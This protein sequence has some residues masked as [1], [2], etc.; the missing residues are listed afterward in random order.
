MA[1]MATLIPAENDMATLVPVA[2]GARAIAQGSS[3]LDETLKAP[4]RVLG[5]IAE[6]AGRAGQYLSGDRVGTDLRRWG[7]GIEDRNA[8]TPEFQ[9]EHPVISTVGGV[10]EG[11]AKMAPYLAADTALAA[12]GVGAP[13]AAGLALPV[14]AGAAQGQTSYEKAIANGM[15][16]DEAIS[17]SRAPAVVTGAGMGAMGVL[18]HE[19]QGIGG[20]ARSI[21]GKFAKHAAADTAIMMGQGVAT[22]EAE[23]L[24]S[25]DPNAQPLD[26]LTN[27]KAWL[28]SALTGAL[29][30]GVGAGQ[31]IMAVRRLAGANT[32]ETY[33][34][35]TDALLHKIQNPDADLGSVIA[36][37][38]APEP[39][40]A[41]PGAAALLGNLGPAFN[42][43]GREAAMRDAI[44]NPA[45][46]GGIRDRALIDYPDQA[47]VGARSILEGMDDPY[48]RQQEAMA[49]APER[50]IPEMVAQVPGFNPEVPF[51][52]ERSQR[53]A[54][55][56]GVEADQRKAFDSANPEIPNAPE[57]LPTDADFLRSAARNVS[58]ITSE[59]HIIDGN[60]TERSW[61]LKS[62]LAP[63]LE[64]AG[65]KASAKDR[66]AGLTDRTLAAKI[67]E[68][69]ANG[70]M[71]AKN[72]KAQEPKVIKGDS[73]FDFGYND[74]NYTP[75]HDT[76]PY[77]HLSPEEKALADQNDQAVAEAKTALADP[78][79]AAELQGIA[80]GGE[81]VKAVRS[82]DFKEDG[83]Y[84]VTMKD[85]TTYG[86][87]RDPEGGG[88]YLE[89]PGHFTDAALAAWTKKDAITALERMHEGG[90][91]RTEVA[92][93]YGADGERL[94]G[95]ALQ[96]SKYSTEA[97]TPEPLTIERIQSAFPG[98]KV[99]KGVTPE[100]QEYHSVVTKS[101]AVFMV[102]QVDGEIRYNKGVV[103]AAYG[104]PLSAGETP[105]ASWTPLDTGSIDRGG[106]IKLT[107]AGVGEL[108]HEV[109]HAAV[110]LALTKGE[111]KAVLK[112]YGNEEAAARAY[113]D[114]RDAPAG[115]KPDTFFQKIKDFFA[116]IRELIAPTAQG[117]FEKIAS[118]EAWGNKIT[119]AQAADPKYSLKDQAQEKLDKVMEVAPVRKAAAT[120][121]AAAD[122]IDRAIMPAGR[123][124]NAGKAGE[125]L[126][127]ELGKMNREV[128]QF[129][130]DLDS[131]V[132]KTQVKGLAKLLDM[133][134]QSGR[135]LADSVFS[136]L[137]VQA[138]HD[139]MQW[140]DTGK[141]PA[142]LDV[143]PEL[144]SIGD[145]MNKEFGKL[146]GEVQELGTH[147]LG[148]IRENYFPH[149]YEQESVR[150]FN[151]ALTEALDQG[152]GG[153]NADLSSWSAA[154]K[155][156][157]RERAQ[158]LAAAGQGL[159]NE[160]YLHLAKRPVEGSRAFTKA[161]VFD[162]IQ[163]AQDFGLKL[164][165]D[166]PI[167]LAY[168]KINEMKKYIMTHTAIKEMAKEIP[169]SVQILPAG[170]QGPKGY[171]A[172]LGPY[173][174]V[175]QGEKAQ[176]PEAKAAYQ[177]SQQ[178]K[179]AVA[180]Q[181][182]ALAEAQAQFG[183]YSPEH[184]A[185]SDQLGK[186]QTLY[187]Q[188]VSD[189]NTMQAP[190]PHKYW[191]KDDVA[192]IY[193]NYL[194]QTLYNNKYVGPMYSTWMK[195]A[196]LLNQWQLGILSGF[197]GGFTS[198]ES[199]LS[200]GALGI[201]AI[202][203]GDFKEGVKFLGEAPMAWLRNPKFGDALL[204]VYRDPSTAGAFAAR[205]EKLGIT[206]K[207]ARGVVDMLELAG[208]KAGMGREFETNTT[209]KAL[210][211][212][213]D[214]KKVKAIARTPQALVEQAARPIMEWLV[215][216]QKFG[217]FGEMAMD[218]MRRNPDASHDETRK[219]AQQIWNRID[220]RLGQVA[221]D[222]L[223]IHNI[224]K[225]VA[226]A[227]IRAP[228]WTG[229]TVLEL[230]GG[231]K[232]IAGWAN[233][234]RK[235]EFAELSDRA[236][237]TI[238]L[239]TGMALA[240]GL[241]TALFTGDIPDQPEDLWAFRTG[242]LD[243]LGRP[244][245]YLLPTY[246]KDVHNWLSDPHKTAANKFHPLIGLASELNQNKDY[247]STE[248][249][250]PD[251]NWLQQAGQVLGYG[252]KAF[253]PFWMRGMGKEAER[254]AT[255]PVN[256]VAPLVGVMPAPADFSMSAAEKE[257]MKILGESRSTAPR[258]QEEFQ[259]SQLVNKIAREQRL[260]QDSG[261][262][263]QSMDNGKLSHRDLAT[264]KEK[265]TM[266][267][268]IR[269]FKKL[270]MDDAIA[271]YEKA[272]VD[273]KER[274]EPVLHR[275]MNVARHN[276]AP[277]EYQTLKERWPKIFGG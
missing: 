212:W 61:S 7:Q 222:R 218:W 33:G 201:K 210:A 87:Y 45:A 239:A 185:A 53:V 230:G 203:R 178:L 183:D 131:S 186:V 202:S 4:A 193:N 92:Y 90:H 189:Y 56:Q 225:N 125:I 197:H 223:F 235:G 105:V 188:A 169:D 42:Q 244:E 190:Q 71:P 11:V 246:W 82:K 23:K 55:Q 14:I 18:S 63:Y 179:G 62:D 41:G 161:R 16:P 52:E 64:D 114:F 199:V 269:G 54:K 38:V 81:E 266:E 137:P 251:D 195:S 26:Q 123:T 167:D 247:Y 117:T 65:V 249:R 84:R 102:M 258:T 166:N 91:P 134:Q 267:P 46:P 173:G 205:L 127:G 109:F 157:V 177:K 273:E 141:A 277:E 253:E 250:H 106:V 145:V 259:R 158:E 198:M 174:T 88:W 262:L 132:P 19:L 101:G 204:N 99:G 172:L 156:L 50:A 229:G 104:R 236:S 3:I 25:I 49:N 220:S 207:E 240:N 113:Q 154:D 194:S 261:L 257:Q 59:N 89:S 83:T 30:A 219:E 119:A 21:A 5:G 43:T 232:D 140:M 133:A 192:Q 94:P 143:T 68:D 271:V 75:E 213:A 184:Q 24:T 96:K 234:A 20:G 148:V 217:V 233:G 120:F 147:A 108:D 180:A 176:A 245:R 256:Y 139:F 22:S 252:V 128:A 118:G 37:T 216:R 264:I 138:R 15:T 112:K 100:G 150:A 196:N 6:E 191:L 66:E 36:D 224:T 265:A 79:K 208:A 272:T 237:Y 110:A 200:H 162:D 221:Y 211:D 97:S 107:D 168:L 48:R 98:Q 124:E 268:M 103:E 116:K 44:I 69:A 135:T 17:A 238:A 8:M 136:K 27:P 115:A 241:L 76:I 10:V 226:Q 155:Q 130:A 231:L 47:G 95:T 28:E 58:D 276:M 164:V 146:A 142:T 13:L 77:E 151:Q 152:V 227:I 73:S 260:G 175:L 85:G 254:G 2:G 111:V 126:R 12:T 270:G 215:P 93:K 159:D 160:M 40:A 144:K 29:F 57:P 74:P 214:D 171:T 78:Q 243:E 228:G 165:S 31:K 51:A 263:Q 242:N 209:Q 86:I 274:L 181:T 275:K 80:S 9:A 129:T 248:I 35:V 32:P 163:T 67:L 187:K 206:G 34:A 149:I 39:L 153:D 255:N 122:G 60:K 170:E 70:K 121:A 1:D 72:N 182:K